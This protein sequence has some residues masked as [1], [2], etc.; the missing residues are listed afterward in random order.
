[1]IGGFEP[2]TYNCLST[3][4]LGHHLIRKRKGSLLSAAVIS[5]VLLEHEF[6]CFNRGRLGDFAV[7]ALDPVSRWSE[8]KKH[9]FSES[10]N[11]QRVSSGD[12]KK[13]EGP[14]AP[15]SKVISPDER[16]NGR[17]KLCIRS[18]CFA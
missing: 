14:P 9:P 2:V 18:R 1:M 4:M 7:P 17:K 3:R 13:R 15:E 12:A 8:G 10:K 16:A 11:R 6:A 5:D